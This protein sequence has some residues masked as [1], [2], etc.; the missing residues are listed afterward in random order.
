MLEEKDFIDVMTKFQEYIEKE[1]E[2]TKLCRSL[3]DFFDFS[4]SH[5]ADLLI[6]VLTKACKDE[7][8]WISYFIWDL[9]FGRN[10]KHGTIKIGKK[11]VRMSN[12][13]ELYKVLKDNYTR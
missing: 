3:N 9:D 13:K 10:Y 1:R 8:E 5:Y 11:N 12:A 6:K 2:I 4:S 7:S